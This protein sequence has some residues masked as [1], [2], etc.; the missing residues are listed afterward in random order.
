VEEALEVIGVVEAVEVGVV[1]EEVQEAT[2][3][4]QEKCTKLHVQNV[5][6]NVKCLS[7][8]PKES[9]FIVRNAIP[10]IKINF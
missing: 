9:Q 1:L 2:L 10:S 7:N 5:N 6:K 3:E 4:V 8:Q